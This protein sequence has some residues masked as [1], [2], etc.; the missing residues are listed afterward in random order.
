MASASDVLKKI[1]SRWPRRRQMALRRVRYHWLIRKGR[2]AANEPEYKRLSEWVGSGDSVID[3]GANIGT[4]TMILSTIVGPAGRVI[5]IEPVPSTF[6][7]LTTHVGG[8][9][10][11]NVTLLNLAASEKSGIVEMEVPSFDSGLDN[12]YRSKIA[13]GGTL[14]VF[15]VAL[16]SLSINERVRLIKIDVEGHELS[17]LRGVI[18]LIRRDKPVLILEGHLSAFDRVL[19]PL[20]YTKKRLDRSPNTVFLPA[21]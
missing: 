20:G 16:D 9:S 1:V 4:Y 21:G 12:I 3:V 18:Q 13:H 11:E 10:G 15:A 5:A 14:R 7:L 8:L 6:Q 19:V 17:V 2:F